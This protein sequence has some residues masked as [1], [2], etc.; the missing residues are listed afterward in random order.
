MNP[1][2]LNK[3][4]T[5]LQLSDIENEY[6]TISKDLTLVIPHPIWARVEP[7][8]GRDYKEEAKDKTE[9]L[10][11]ITIRYRPN[12][13][14]DMLIGYKNAVYAIQNIADPAEK[15]EQLILTCSITNRGDANHVT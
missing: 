1:G 15:H 9:D 10:F 8:S 12:I 14:N 6:G 2:R 4:V 7:F 3:R 13:S 11:K 5:L